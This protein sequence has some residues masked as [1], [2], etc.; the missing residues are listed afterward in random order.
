LRK[1]AFVMF[2]FVLL[3][4]SLV[5]SRALAAE[6][7]EEVYGKHGMVASGHILA[8]QAGVEIMKQGGNAIDAA[9]ATAFALTVVEGNASGLGGGGFMVIRFAETK[10]VVALDYREMAPKSSTKDMFASKQAQDEEWSA[11]GGK[12]SGVPGW[13]KGL[14]YALE[15]YGTMSLAQVTAPAVRYAEE[16]FVPLPRQTEFIKD[17]F[18][19][20]STHNDPAK[21]RF[22]KDGL[23]LPAGETLKQPELGKTIRLFAEKGPDV[24]YGGEVGAA[25]VAAINKAGGNMTIDDLKNYQLQ[26]RKPIEGTYRNY[27]IYSM[28]PAS[29]GGTHVIQ[30]LNVMEN[31][32]VRRMGHNSPELLQ[33]MAETQKMIYADRAKFMADTAFTKVP[34][35]GLAN[36]EYAKT[37]V[38]RINR[39]KP[40]LEGIEAGDPWPFNEEPKTSGINTIAGQPDHNF[41]TV[42]LSVVDSGGNIVSATHTIN[43]YFGSGVIVPE[44]GFLMNDQMD[45]FASNP[46][47]VNAPEPGKRP[48][49]SMSP[50]IVMTPEGKPFAA[51]GAAGGTRIMMGVAQVIMNIVDFGMKMSEAIEQPRLIAWQSGGKAADL[52]LCPRVSPQIVR[53]ME[54]RGYTMNLANNASCNGILFNTETGE[55]NGAA[56]SRVVGAAAGY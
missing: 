48:L 8:S 3:F 45:D 15:K 34:L 44:Y 16:G 10:E 46:E 5:G 17:A 13:L 14:T 35:T 40:V 12:A 27:K 23:P 37:I 41:S 31:F 47:S 4:V 29:S 49:S 36:K 28:P 43:N 52:R 21:V 24:L 39:D 1:F 7:V 51:L 38:S 11:Y 18:E 25:L 54:A 26:V 32:D 42:H 56:D 20:L 50:T 55:L 22:F 33:I 30:Y 9:V 6:P 53:A 2:V 19:K